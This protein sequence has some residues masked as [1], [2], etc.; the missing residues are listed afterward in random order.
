MLSEVVSCIFCEGV[1][2]E[3]G[4]KATILGF[5][6]ILPYVVLT[7]GTPG[8]T[9][10]VI[11]FTL[12]FLTLGEGEA[13]ADFAIYNP[14][15]TVLAE[16]KE[17]HLDWNSDDQVSVLVLRF[18]L[19]ALKAVGEYAIYLHSDGIEKFKSFFKVRLHPKG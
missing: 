9:G 6:G 8:E 5:G 3:V 10:Q 19:K 14:D 15:G 2:Q 12:L 13:S 11:E 17:V 4:G 16:Q 18:Q 1:R 7:L